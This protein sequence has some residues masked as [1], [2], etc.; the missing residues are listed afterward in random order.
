MA[1]SSSDSVSHW[2][3]IAFEMSAIDPDGAIGRRYRPRAGAAVECV[4]DFAPEGRIGRGDGD[5]AVDELVISGPGGGVGE[6]GPRWVPDRP[7]EVL[8]GGALGWEAG[9]ASR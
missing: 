3:K 8:D 9:R 4:W 5:C 2:W 7:I 1:S 6:D